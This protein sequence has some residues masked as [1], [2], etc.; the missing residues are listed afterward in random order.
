VSDQA[1]VGSIDQFAIEYLCRAASS[2][3]PDQGEPFL[4]ILEEFLNVDLCHGC[5]AFQLINN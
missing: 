5:Q 1:L 3:D 4:F 2:G